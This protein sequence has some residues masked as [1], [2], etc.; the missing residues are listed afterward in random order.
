MNYA[1]EFTPEAGEGLARLPP[2]TASAVLDGIDRLASDPVGLSRPSYFPY[3]PGRQW[4]QFWVGTSEGRYWVTV[5]FRYGEGAH[6]IILLGLAA[7]R[8]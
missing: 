2:L 6:R 5:F 7:Q 1:V 4:Y 8:V 3:L